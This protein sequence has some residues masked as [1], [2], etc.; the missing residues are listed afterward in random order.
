MLKKGRKV[1]K[2][3]KKS[4][5]GEKSPF[6]ICSKLRKTFLKCHKV[7]ISHESRKVN[8]L[9]FPALVEIF[10][11]FCTHLKNNLELKPYRRLIF[12]RWCKDL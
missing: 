1:G 5:A 8:Q 2:K 6:Q 7:T 9:F 11:N 10:N 3:V 12:H 4:I